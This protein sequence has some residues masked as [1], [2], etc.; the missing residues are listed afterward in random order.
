MRGY[1]RTFS[2]F[3]VIILVMGLI[4]PIVFA[5]DK[6]NASGIAIEIKDDGI[7]D[8]L[9][10]PNEEFEVKDMIIRL[11]KGIMNISDGNEKTKELIKD[12]LEY[13][14]LE[15]DTSSFYIKDKGSKIRVDLSGKDGEVEEDKE[16]YATIVIKDLKLVYTGTGNGRIPITFKYKIKNSDKENFIKDNIGVKVGN[17]GDEEEE[18]T[19]KHR[20]YLKLDDESTYD[21]EAGDSE[22]IDLEIRNASSYDA[23]DIIISAVIEES[24][25]PIFFNGD[26]SFDFNRIHDGK[27]KDIELDIEVE[28]TAQ[29]GSYPIKLEYKFTNRA[30]NEF[31]G[32]DTIYIKV[33][34]NNVPPRLIMNPN[35]MEKDFIESGSES[36]I[37]LEIENKGSLDA[38][39]IKVTLEG[40]N[41]GGF[42]LGYGT[43]T[44]YI[45]SIDD[46][47]IETID[48]LLQA[49]DKME[50]GSYPLTFKIEYTDDSK[51]KYTDEQKF[52]LDVR[53][54]GTSKSNISID[55]LES[56]KESYNVNEN[57]S[58]KFDLVNNGRYNAQ[59]AK[60]SIETEEHIIPKSQNI[61]IIRNISP[62]DKVPME[63]I[64]CATDK[65][66]SRNYPIAI[67]VEYED[68]KSNKSEKYTFS[69]YVGVNIDNGQGN[70]KSVPKIIVSEYKSDPVIVNAGEEF[71][72]Y[73]QF[74]NTHSS[75]LIRN[76]KVFLTIEQETDENVGTGNV[77]TPVKS[78]NTFYIDSIGPKQ[79]AARSL[80][81]Y[82]MPD[83]KPKYYEVTANFEYEDGKGEQ[84]TAKEL[85]GIHVKQPTELEIGDVEIPP[86]A[87]V[88]QPSPV[89]L[90][91]YNTGRVDL[92]NLK[93]E[94]QGDFDTQNGSFFFG[95]FD[96]GYS[97]YFEGMVIPN[98]AGKT[99]G[100]IVATYE[101]VSGEEIKVTKDF[102]IN[103]MEMPA[104]DENGPPM[105]QPPMEGEE[106]NGS[107]WKNKYL[108]AGLGTIILLGAIFIIRKKIKEK[109]G[110]DFDE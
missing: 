11:D 25:S 26:N 44:R 73:L 47:E 35:F 75:K 36:L 62:G 99:E 32:S 51:E 98:Q 13:L 57:F 102:S 96:S 103:A 4:D 42:T 12:E 64:L 82:T 16:E 29:S 6:D 1:C 66:E 34:N 7:K 87:Y 108:W 19:K 60:V 68:D 104:M 69:Q 52:F 59:N 20:P 14:Y 30:G 86:E 50:S 106:E 39:D 56:L 55:N 5:Q 22:D 28:K 71:D 85:I 17:K 95:N 78:S 94:L 43:N 33:T 53:S 41:P 83:A 77:F 90:Q 72:L 49:S 70:S 38:K 97:D 76:I 61:K 92:R 9:I 15:I 107:I 74:K 84:H 10:Y 91:I 23:Q 18:D 40:L 54:E 105:E 67:N 8:D 24:S 79:T 58:I 27:S 109:K 21:V 31:T 88:G 93:V 89:S 80:K 3:M 110:M 63:F 101:D 45:N 2:F 100:K 48:F 65:A 37:F 46:S 81:M